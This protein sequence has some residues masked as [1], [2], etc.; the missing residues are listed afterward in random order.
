M[1]KKMII[2]TGPTAVGK[3]SLSIKLCQKIGGDIISADS[4]QIY[5]YM[6]I[7]TAKISPEEMAGVKHYLIDELDPSEEFN[8]FVFK[9]MAKEALDRIYEND[10]I[11]VLVGGTGFYINALLFDTE[12]EEEDNSKIR[13]ELEKLLQEKGCEYLYGQLKEKDPEYAATLHMNNTKRV[14][15]ALEYITLNNKKF[16]LHNKEEKAKESPYDYYYF[17]LNDARDKLYEKIEKRIDL[18]IKEGLVDE[19]RKLKDMGFDKNYVSM[20]GLG[21]K[22]IL[23]YLTG[24]CTLD[25]AVY[26]LKIRTRHFAKRQLTWFRGQKEVIWINKNEFDHDEDRILDFIERKAKLV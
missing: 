8:V 6:D 19:V 7:G 4:M 3:T 2:L 1:K 5:K 15:R 21:Y 13:A 12:F 22:E 14:I 9:K 16:S 17:V 25:E 18:M 24:E 23:D 20:Q 26:N 11:P 10:R